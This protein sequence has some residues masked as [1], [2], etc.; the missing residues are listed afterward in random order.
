MGERICLQRS[1]GSDRI[2]IPSAPT[3][4]CPYLAALMCSGLLRWFTSLFSEGIILAKGEKGVGWPTL[5][6]CLPTKYF[7]VCLSPI[8]HLILTV[9]IGFLCKF[10]LL[11]IYDV[12]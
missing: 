2:S 5:L 8:F 1:E 9:L 6:S 7:F 10:I 12:P 3:H 11:V 4:F